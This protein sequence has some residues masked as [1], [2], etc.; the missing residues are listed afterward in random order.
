MSRGRPR[1]ALSRRLLLLQVLGT[2]EPPLTQLFPL[3]LVLL[4]GAHVRHAAA[5]LSV[6]AE[7]CH[8][9]HARLL[10]EPPP[11]IFI[12]ARPWLMFPEGLNRA[13]QRSSAHRHAVLG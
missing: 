10:S 12:T 1:S 7:L 11:P 3:V 5:L 13:L 9:I 2:M 6:S 4:I 8:Y